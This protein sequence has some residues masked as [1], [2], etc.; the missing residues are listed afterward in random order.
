[1][2]EMVDALVEKAKEG[3]VAAAR[4]VLSYTVGRPGAAVDPDR[5]DIEEF[6]IYQQEAK[7]HDQFM[8]PIKGVPAGL[9]CDMLRGIMP[10]LTEDYR[11]QGVQAFAQYEA[12]QADDDEET[13]AS[14]PAPG[15]DTAASATKKTEPAASV[16]TS[17]ASGQR[18]GKASS[19]RE[20][21]GQQE[22]AGAEL[23]SVEEILSFLQAGPRAAV[24]ADEGD[25]GQEE[26]EETMK[27]TPDS[28][29]AAT[30]C[31]AANPDQ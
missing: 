4:L 12:Q 16:L 25:A 14:E 21:K 26:G 7:T 30:A 10:A 22:K 19:T 18:Q 23:P 9:A 2:R 1:M 6:D 27:D 15:S 29:R 17:T 3:D 24:A 5:L 11:R 20:E 13:A 8:T 28:K 31:R